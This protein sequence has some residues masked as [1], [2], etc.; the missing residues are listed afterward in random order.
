MKQQQKEIE[1]LRDKKFTLVELLVVIA[2]IAIL[3]SMLLPALERAKA[4]AKSLQCKGNLKQ[5]GIALGCYEIDYNLLPAPQP[6]GRNWAGLLFDA[7]ILQAQW[8]TYYGAVAGNCPILDCPVNVDLF[9]MNLLDY[10]RFNYGISNQLCRRFATEDLY[11]ASARNIIP[12]NRFNITKPSER[13]LLG[14]NGSTLLAHTVGVL[15]GPNES[16]GPNEG[17]AYPHD[18]T[19]NI[20]YLDYHVGAVSRQA[21]SNWRFYQPLFG[22]TE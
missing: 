12:I 13:L 7:G 19:M 16:M 22:I 4:S 6:P 15:G 5:L 10:E 17:S 18:R 14:E 2:I 3:A 8:Y 20:L 21:M 9:S 1:M 11:Y